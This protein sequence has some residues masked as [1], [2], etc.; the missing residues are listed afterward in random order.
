MADGGARALALPFSPP[1]P[2][3]LSS[4]VP[5]NAR[6]AVSCP[7]TYTVPSPPTARAKMEPEVGGKVS[8]RT[9]AQV[10]FLYEMPASAA[11]A[12]PVT[13]QRR[14]DYEDAKGCLH[15]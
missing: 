13:A 10:S 11:A 1:P 8:T 5:L 4:P 14:G 9:Q 12:P 6:T 3:P 15:R 2:P 7:A